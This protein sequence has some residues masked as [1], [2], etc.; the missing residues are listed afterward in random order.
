MV[1]PARAKAGLFTVHYSKD[2]VS[3]QGLLP[4]VKDLGTLV[5][6]SSPAGQPTVCTDIIIPSLH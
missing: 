5:Q 2:N 6:G 4:F 1:S 3:L